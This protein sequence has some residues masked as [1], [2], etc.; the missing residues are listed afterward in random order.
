MCSN[1][2]T[3]SCTFGTPLRALSLQLPR[4]GNAAAAGGEMDRRAHVYKALEQHRRCLV[5]PL[6]PLF[7]LLVFLGEKLLEISKTR[8][9]TQTT[10]TTRQ[11][12]AQQHHGHC[13]DDLQ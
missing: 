4:S 9:G 8:Q 7:S 10:Q 3:M 13:Y 11:E 5:A 12:E 1:V 2:R 6:M